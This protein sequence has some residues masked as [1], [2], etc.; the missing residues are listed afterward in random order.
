MWESN[1]G[2]N[3]GGRRYAVIEKNGTRRKEKENTSN[4]A[5]EEV[6]SKQQ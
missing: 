2:C 3:N 1:R 5:K 4:I 6:R